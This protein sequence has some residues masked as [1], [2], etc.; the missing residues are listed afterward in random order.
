MVDRYGNT[1]VIGWSVTEELW[2]EAIIKMGSQ[3]A[4]LIELS[5]LTGRSLEAI[6]QKM[7]RRRKAILR[8]QNRE[9]LA[10]LARRF[11]LIGSCGEA[12]NA[13]VCQPEASLTSS[14]MRR[15]VS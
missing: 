6:K 4:H 1:I 11:P 8:K 2:L 15:G 12:A 5:E 13:S 7:V 14:D 9:T 3:R 10:V